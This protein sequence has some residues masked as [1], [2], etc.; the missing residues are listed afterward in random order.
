MIE[1]TRSLDINANPEVVWQSIADFGA[2]ASFIK[3]IKECTTEGEDGVGQLRHLI[4]E[5]NSLTTSR[6]AL[7]D[8]EQRILTYEIVTT[9]LPMDDY[10]STMTVS[11][12]GNNRCN[13][14]WCSRFE[15]AGV[16][17]EK[18]EDYIGTQL[19]AALQ[20]LKALHE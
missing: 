13:V 7:L 4:L 11:D 17:P 19:A 20:N 10:N 15:P 3:T 6:L 16:L 18:I 12:I 14:N 2:V 1:V 8:N 5:D 9:A